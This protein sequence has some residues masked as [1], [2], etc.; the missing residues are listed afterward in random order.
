MAK[1]TEYVWKEVEQ[2]ARKN[3]EEA[4]HVEE[5]QRVISGQR[6][7]LQKLR[8]KAKETN[9]VSQSTAPSE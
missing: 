6:E 4:K 8:V 7:K 3:E 9:R 2:M 5:L 1:K